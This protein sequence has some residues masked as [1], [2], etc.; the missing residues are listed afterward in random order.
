MVEPLLRILGWAVPVESFSAAPTIVAPAAEVPEV[1]LRW[2]KPSG[3]AFSAAQA[4]RQT[5]S[6]SAEFPPDKTL[7]MRVL[8]ADAQIDIVTVNKRDE[9]GAFIHVLRINSIRF[10]YS[11][12]QSRQDES[13]LTF[14]RH[15]SWDLRLDQHPAD[16]EEGAVE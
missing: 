1:G 14:Y 13:G 11:E 16:E 12:P 5:S 6:V 10:S 2:G 8:D 7:Y 3:F 4:Q 15:T 9:S